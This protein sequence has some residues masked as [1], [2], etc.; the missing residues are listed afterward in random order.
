MKEPNKKIPQYLKTYFWDTKLNDINLKTN[1]P[2]VIERILELGDK[3]G[4]HWLL[5]T[6]QPR[7]IKA[8]VIRS[9]NISPKTANFWRLKLD[10]KE[11]ILCLSKQFQKQQKMFW[12]I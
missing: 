5:E 8:T 4:I 10:I 2:F 1:S 6:Y 3:K 7:D 9:R 12:R 11:P